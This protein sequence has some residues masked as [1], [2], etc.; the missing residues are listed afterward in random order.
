[1]LDAVLR[2]LTMLLAADDASKARFKALVG[3]DTLL[4]AILNLQPH[5]SR[6]TLHRILDLM[7]EGDFEEGQ[8]GG[9]GD[10]GDGGDGGGDDG[11]DEHGTHTIRNEH[12]VGVFFSALRAA[13]PEL[14][15]LYNTAAWGLLGGLA[16]RTG[17]TAAMT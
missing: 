1:M 15:V 17:W 5:P 11:G 16:R 9:G 13:E 14:Q 4:H 12:M 3:Y 7:V 2:T 6:A 10:R 8:A